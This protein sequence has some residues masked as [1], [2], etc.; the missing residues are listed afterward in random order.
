MKKV[1]SLV[2]VLAMVLGSFSFVLAAPLS[3]IAGT[4]YEEAGTRL[5]LLEILKGYPDGTFKPENQITRAEFAAVAIRAKGLESTAQAAKGLA[6]GFS[7]VPASNWASGYVGTAAKLGIVNGVGNGQFAPDAPVKYEEAITMLVR[8]LGYEEAAKQ[9]GGYPYGYLIVANENG[10]LDAVKGGTQGAPATRGTVAQLVDNALEIP[11]MIQV[12]YGTN[13]K[14]VV[15]GSKEH[16]DEAEERYLLDDMGFESVKGRVISVTPKTNK[17]TVEQDKK[18]VTLKVTEGFDFYAVEG[19]ETK[20][21]YKNDTVVVH[22]VKEEAKFDA[23]EV[24][25]DKLKLV[26]E[27]EKYDVAKKPILTL[28]DKSVDQ[29]EFNADYAKIVL[30]DDDEIIWAQGYTFD[31]FILVDEVK[32]N[33]IIGYGDDELKVKDFTIVKEGKTIAAEDLE[34]GEIVFY[35]LDKE[36]AVVATSSKDG[37][38]ERVYSDGFRLD[39]KAYN[40]TTLAD[41]KYFDGKNLVELDTDLLDEIEEDGDEVTIFFSFANK[42]VVVSGK[43]KDVDASSFYAVLTDG[44]GFT[45]GRRGQNYVSIDVRT[46]DNSK[47]SY[48][49]SYD[50]FNDS[51]LFNVGVTE[52]QFNAV[53]N[54]DALLGLLNLN[55]SSQ[56]FE[57]E[58]D[59]IKVTVDKDGDVTKI[60]VPENDKIKTAF[61][62]SA[63]YAKGDNGDYRLNASTVVFYDGNKKAIKIGDIKDEFEEIRNT[64]TGRIYYESG[65]AVAIVSETNADADTKTVTGKVERIG[66]LSNGAVELRVKVAGKTETYVADNKASDKNDAIVKNQIVKLTIGEKSGKI[67]DLTENVTINDVTY[68]KGEL[69]VVVP[70]HE[71]VTIEEVSNRNLTDTAKKKYDLAV[72][73]RF[74]L[75][76]NMN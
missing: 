26:T 74:L 57:D 76:R 43:D 10:L 50:V 16:G 44:V 52:N 21:W 55:A 20:F 62:V 15:S 33:E 49:L 75:E 36:F 13:T 39:G 28:N 22:K 56:K 4:V 51:K 19:L 31:G 9:K 8:A 30:N 70:K 38:I 41:V 58:N 69:N 48:D 46:A 23:V 11:L 72:S 61:K 71:K 66:S 59:V 60:A 2:L 73:V 7:D 18:N 64:D 17:L 54:V 6:T 65:K 35:N 27:N 5:E 68:K 25:K 53:K 40:F 34:D 3:D 63:S 14:W 1:L 47:K 42:V 45:T 67:V 29:D 24:A 37:K 32:D 12:G